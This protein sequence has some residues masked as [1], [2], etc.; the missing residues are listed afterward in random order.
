MSR[1]GRR[2]RGTTVKMWALGLGLVM[3]LAGFALEASSGFTPGT[4]AFAWGLL[5]LVVG[6]SVAFLPNRKAFLGR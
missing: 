1:R 3:I 5:L 2:T 6:G 4:P